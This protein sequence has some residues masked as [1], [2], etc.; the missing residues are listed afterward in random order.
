MLPFQSISLRSDVCLLLEG[1]YVVSVDGIF[2]SCT[3]WK[4]IE[5][6]RAINGIVHF[7]SKNVHQELST[8]FFQTLILFIGCQQ[9]KWNNPINVYIKYINGG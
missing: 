2:I 1:P 7:K 8:S 9:Q 3:Q 6:N 5:V 4:K